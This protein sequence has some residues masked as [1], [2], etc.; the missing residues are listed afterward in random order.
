M[1]KNLKIIQ[2]SYAAGAKND[3]LKMLK[4][5]TD[6]SIWIETAGGPYGGTYIGNDSV[7]KDVFARIKDDWEI[8]A[9]IP[10]EFYEAEDTVIMTGW[11]EGTHAKTKNKM[12]IRVAHVWQLAEGK[13]IKFEQFTDTALLLEAMKG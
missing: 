7:L 4:D 1:C 2:E 12:K 6:K 8:F 10:E 11:Y 3:I 9:C 5:L 13:V